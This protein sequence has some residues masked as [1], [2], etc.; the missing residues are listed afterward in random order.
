MRV[1]VTRI[2]S[3]FR[4]TSVTNVSTRCNQILHI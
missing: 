3:N 4:S 1:Q 2:N